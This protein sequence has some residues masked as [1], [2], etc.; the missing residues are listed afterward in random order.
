[1]KIGNN[2]IFYN[3]DLDSNNIRSKRTFI[4]IKNG[5]IYNTKE[6]PVKCSVIDRFVCFMMKDV[7]LV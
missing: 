6:K 7:I 3:A 2:L 5:K 1:M 4:K